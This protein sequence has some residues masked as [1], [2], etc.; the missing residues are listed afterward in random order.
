MGAGA[1]GAAVD[2]GVCAVIDEHPASNT[3]TPKVTPKNTKPDE[4]ARMT[5]LPFC[6]KYI[7]RP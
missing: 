2:A 6:S 7:P 3:V 5:N 1:G 4:I